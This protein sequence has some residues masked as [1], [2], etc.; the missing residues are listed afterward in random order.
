ML[1]V[2]WRLRA[3]RCT[4]TVTLGR[5]LR[6]TELPKLRLTGD[7]GGSLSITI[8]DGVDLGRMIL[9]D[10]DV[11]RDSTLVIG[12]ATTFEYAVRIQLQG[13]QIGVGAGCE[14][15]DGTTLKVSSSAAKLAIG[16]QVKIGRGVAVHCHETVLISDLVTLADRVTLVDSLHDVDGSDTWTMDAAL[17][18]EPIRIERNVI[19]YTGAVIVLGTTI[20]SNSVVAANALVQAG[21]HDSSVVLVGNPARPV[22][23][24][25]PATAPVGAE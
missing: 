14:V 7:R 21:I 23:R 1:A 20:G 10:V 15:R 6:C 2:R 11:S 16:D 18:T 8:G 19:I 9:L 22:R 4:L 12:G 17:R 25:G 5:K 24:L 13:G 3:R